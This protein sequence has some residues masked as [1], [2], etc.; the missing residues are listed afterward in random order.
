M[1]QLPNSHAFFFLGSLSF[2]VYFTISVCACVCVHVQVCVFVQWR[3]HLPLPVCAGLAETRALG[4]TNRRA[5]PQTS[6]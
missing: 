2:S 5:V 1:V 3:T 4:V 6:L